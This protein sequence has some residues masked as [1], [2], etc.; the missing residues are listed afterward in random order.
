MGFIMA[1]RQCKGICKTL[2]NYSPLKKID[3]A[4][5]QGWKKCFSPCECHFYR[6]ETTLCPC[7]NTKLRTSHIRRK[8]ETKEKAKM[9]KKILQ[10]GV[11]K[12]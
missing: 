5:E 6:Q 10:N 11:A 3:Y 8:P 7:C 1:S 4:Y 2:S 12:R 9:L